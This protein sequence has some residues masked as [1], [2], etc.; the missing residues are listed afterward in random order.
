MGD[1]GFVCLMRQQAVRTE[2]EAKK[3]LRQLRKGA[4]GGRLLRP[5]KTHMSRSWLVQVFYSDD[6]PASR[7]PT[8]YARLLLPGD[9]DLKAYGIDPKRLDRPPED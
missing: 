7:V 2:E 9:T 4:L 5:S 1:G 6:N 3:L 8:G